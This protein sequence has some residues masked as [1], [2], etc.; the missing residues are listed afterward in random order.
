MASALANDEH[1]PCNREGQC[2]GVVKIDGSGTIYPQ[3]IR[4]RAYGDGGL[5]GFGARA[6]RDDG[7][8]RTG[9]DARTEPVAIAAIQRVP[10]N[11]YCAWWPNTEPFLVRRVIGNEVEITARVAVELL[12][13]VV[14][15]PARKTFEEKLYQDLQAEQSIR[16]PIPAPYGIV[17]LGAFVDGKCLGGLVRHFAPTGNAVAM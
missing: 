12:R 5:K 15:D 14:V 7:D 17:L 13:V 2:R 8:Q 10:W 1:L 16:L 3:R 9:R 11:V 6:A 4:G